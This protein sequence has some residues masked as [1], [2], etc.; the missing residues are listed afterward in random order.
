MHQYT[1]FQAKRRTHNSFFSENVLPLNRCLF[2]YILVFAGQL[3]LIL[4]VSSCLLFACLFVF[5]VCCL[6]LFYCV[7]R[8]FVMLLTKC[9]LLTYLSKSAFKVIFAV[10]IWEWDMCPISLNFYAKSRG[11]NRLSLFIL[12]KLLSS[13]FERRKLLLTPNAGRDLQ[14]LSSLSQTGREFHK[15]SYS[16]DGILRHRH[17]SGRLL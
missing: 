11:L 17:S 3:L 6:W 13:E 2:C 15:M 12:P 4:C 16:L 5:T 8:A 1:R 10:F 9:N 14:H 7:M